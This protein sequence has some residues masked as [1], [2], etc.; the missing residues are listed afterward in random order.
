MGLLL[1][2]LAH[3]QAKCLAALGRFASLLYHVYSQGFF[4]LTKQFLSYMFAT[5][6]SNVSESEQPL[7]SPSSSS[8]LGLRLP[9]LP[10]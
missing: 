10:L 8:S 2:T 7:L 1:E 6:K 5:K 4:S 3:H 9:L